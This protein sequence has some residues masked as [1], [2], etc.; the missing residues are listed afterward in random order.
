MY[1]E[2]FGLKE[3]S[4]SITPDPHYLY[5]SRRHREALAHLLYGAGDSGGFVLLTGEVGTGKTTVCRAFLEQL[6]KHVDVALILNS[7]MSVPELL[8]AVCEELGIEV[9]E[10]E[11]SPK[12]LVDR[13]NRYLL[14]THAKG[15]RPVLMIDEAQNLKTEVLEQIRLL[16]NLETHKH[17]LLQIFLV[18]QPELR[19]LLQQR[20]LRQLSQRITARYHLT[21]LNGEETGEYIRHRLAVAGVKRPLFTAAAVRRIFRLSGGVPR[22]VNILCDRSLLGAF[23][24]HKARVDRRIVSRASRELHGKPHAKEWRQWF[25]PVALATLALT[26]SIGLGWLAYAWMDESAARFTQPPPP[27][28]DSARPGSSQIVLPSGTAGNPAD[29]V[30]KAD[31][32]TA[33]T[34]QERAPATEPSGEQKTLATASIEKPPQASA[35]VEQTPPP[36]LPPVFI[37]DETEALGLLLK[38][39]AIDLPRD[40]AVA[41][42]R[43]VESRSLRCRTGTGDWESLQF[44]DRPA[45]L[46]VTGESGQAGYALVTGLGPE[47]VTLTT[48]ETQTRFPRSTIDT[49]WSGEFLFL[50]KPAR[51]ERPLID[52][53]SPTEAILWLKQTLGQVPGVALKEP[54]SALF[55]DALRE[56]IKGFQR[57][58]GLE[59]DGIVGPE[60]LIQLNTAAGVPDI[61]QLR[62]TR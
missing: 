19:E 20:N 33:E 47:E 5:L 3:A 2:Y 35:L 61:P 32:P 6:P 48:G 31:A 1:P 30:E 37:L 34:P 49:I 4:F 54:E 13:L 58:Y 16:T 44:Y 53:G 40:L 8:H 46:E 56:S 11:R 59:A 62:T 14:E 25:R 9:P 57:E 42:C 18:G 45:L 26:L 50:W 28:A 15:R 24:T 51:G 22:L 43:F 27:E 60:T 39:W 23:A 36:D 10:G 41:P 55:D 17:K 38:Q 52:P 29:P 21:P 7:A 12:V